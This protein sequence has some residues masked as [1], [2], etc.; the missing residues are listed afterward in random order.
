MLI[1]RGSVHL[2]AQARQPGGLSKCVAGAGSNGPSAD[3]LATDHAGLSHRFQ[4]PVYLIEVPRESSIEYVAFFITACIEVSRIILLI[5]RVIS[6]QLIGAEH[7]PL[8]SKR[9]KAEMAVR[10]VVQRMI[11]K[12]L[13][14]LAQKSDEPPRSTFP[15]APHRIKGLPYVRA[16]SGRNESLQVE[17][18]I[19]PSYARLERP[20]LGGVD[21]GE[22]A[23]P[24]VERILVHRRG[25]VLAEGAV[26]FDL[27][28]QL[29][30]LVEMK[31]GV[32]LQP[33]D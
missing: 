29:P 18:E 3:V 13:H 6:G 32:K 1:A 10:R 27:Q 12:V 15:V 23:Q 31:V 33:L 17:S 20:G 2:D 24:Q 14:G 8:D 7:L 9:V 5:E 16:V 22:K 21:I 26:I 25:N 30:V 11:Q 28:E 4:I 19:L